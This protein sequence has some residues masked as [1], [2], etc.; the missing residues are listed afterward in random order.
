MLLAGT[1]S[2][3]IGCGLWLLAYLLAWR[4]GRA[5]GRSAFPGVAIALNLSWEFTWTFLR[6]PEGDYISDFQFN[7]VVLGLLW[8]GANALL[9]AQWLRHEARTTGRRVAVVVTVAI[10]FGAQHAFAVLTGD[11]SGQLTAFAVNLVDSVAFLALLARRPHGEGLSV[12]AAWARF[13]GTALVALPYVWLFPVISPGWASYAPLYAVFAA[14]AAMDLAYAILLGS[15][16]S[17]ASSAR[18]SY[19]AQ[20]SR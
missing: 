19:Q 13:A 12:G 14:I 15:R 6:S 8:M 4:Q 18:S 20:P 11:R 10:A 3:T 16:R 17:R 2:A 7:L 9:A 5:E 1:A